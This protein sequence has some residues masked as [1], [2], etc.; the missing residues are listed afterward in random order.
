ME[1]N[2][3]CVQFVWWMNE[4]ISA[5]FYSGP[6]TIHTNTIAHTCTHTDSFMPAYTLT[7]NHHT[8]CA[9]TQAQMHAYTKKWT[10]VR[11]HSHRESEKTYIPIQW[12]SHVMVVTIE[13]KRH[14][15]V[16]CNTHIDWTRIRMNISW[17]THEKL[18]NF[19]HKL[20]DELWMYIF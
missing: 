4:H 7:F 16:H 13:W 2:F 14:E 10:S 19:N 1:S 6:Y 18:L 12:Q 11:A 20:F 15:C 8:R 17:M 9:R 3:D 5:I